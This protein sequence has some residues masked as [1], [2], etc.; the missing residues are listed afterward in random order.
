MSP[1]RVVTASLIKPES[2]I[3][4]IVPDWAVFSPEKVLTALS[5]ESSVIDPAEVVALRMSD[6]IFPEGSCVISP[7]A[8]SIT[9]ETPEEIMPLE[10]RPVI[11]IVDREVSVIRPSSVRMFP[12]LSEM[13]VNEMMP[14]GPLFVALNVPTL[15]SREFISMLPA[16]TASKTPVVITEDW[17][18]CWI[19]DVE[20]IL[21]APEPESIPPLSVCSA[22]IKVISPLKVATLLIVTAEPLAKL[23]TPPASVFV[24][25]KIS[26]EFAVESSSILPT[27]VVAS[28]LIVWIKDDGSCVILPAAMIVMK[29]EA[30]SPFSILISPAETSAL[31]MLPEF[32]PLRR[33]SPLPVS[34]VMSMS[35]TMLLEL[36]N[37]IV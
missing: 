6:S 34:S 36:S 24:A 13:A 33:R 4:V 7:L 17:R 16:D 21:I 5:M 19:P 32:T 20:S 27:E 22:A 31:T 29:L 15:L 35:L 2:L 37:L 11:E 10:I 18:F 30:E 1:F 26:T 8:A 3:N 9:L 23:M 12:T 14:V 28:R 25:L